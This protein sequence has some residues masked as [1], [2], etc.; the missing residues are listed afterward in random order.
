MV[1]ATVFLTIIG[2]TAGFVLGERHRE[3][4]RSDDFQVSTP[5]PAADPKTTD[6]TTDPT[7]GPTTG[8]PTRAAGR[9][10]P[11]ES[12]ETAAELGLRTDLNQIMRIVTEEGTVV[13]ICEDGAGALYYQ[14]KTG[15]RDAPLVQKKNGLFLTKVERQGEQEYEAVAENGNRIV[16]TG[17][18][19]EVHF[20]NGA[21]SEISEVAEAQ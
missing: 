14:G 3:R 16:V 7:T 4:L 19:L 6:P 1:I 13:W 11:P 5:T 20:A 12:I 9:S 2:M 15:G 10:C 21:P 8:P 18:R 17:E